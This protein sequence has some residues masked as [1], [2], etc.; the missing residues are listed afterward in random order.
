MDWSPRTVG[1]LQVN[2]EPAGAHVLVDNVPR[3]VTPLTLDDVTLGT[4]TV[5]LQS[6]TGSV[7]RSVTVKSDEPATLSEN[8]YAGWIK[9]LAPFDITISEGSKLLRLDDRDQVMLP[10]GPHDIRFDNRAFGFTE[11][12]HIEVQ[13]GVT[14]P[15]SIAPPYTTLTLTTS[16]PAELLIDG[17]NVGKTPLI[18]YPVQ[19]GTRDV[20]VKS[21]AGNRRLSIP[22]TVKPVVVE[23][24]LSKP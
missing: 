22:A 24:D 9:V 16:A 4:H 2:S 19:I 7:K 20:Q 11:T 23:V 10:A 21:A 13:P 8:I 3:G 5:V 12:R 18:D 15:L 17:E 1:R 6:G 14:T